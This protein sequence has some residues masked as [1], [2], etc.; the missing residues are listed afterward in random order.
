M[1]EE[2]AAACSVHREQNLIANP[3]STYLGAILYK[4]SVG[5][6]RYSTV[7]ICRVWG[8]QNISKIQ[9]RDELSLVTKQ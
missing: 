7:P 3:V 8:N 6:L 4:H 1:G 2:E 9:E 5:W